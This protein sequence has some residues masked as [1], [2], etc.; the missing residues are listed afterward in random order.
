[1]NPTKPLIMAFLVIICLAAM[2]VAAQIPF[3][4]SGYVHFP[5]GSA[6]LDPTVTITNLNTGDILPVMTLPTSNYYQAKPAPLLNE[7]SEN[8]VLEFR[9]SAGTDPVVIEH[10]IMA[11]DINSGAL[12]LNITL[13]TVKAATGS[14]AG[15]P[16]LPQ[17]PTA[18]TQDT[19]AT[20]T[21]TPDDTTATMT[22]VS[23]STEASSS[24]DSKEKSI[25]GFE[26]VFSSVAMV[27]CLMWVRKRGRI[28]IHF[29][30]K[31]NRPHC[32]NRKMLLHLI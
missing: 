12:F 7:I 22:P 31:G 14:G 15:D 26:I 21:T 17:A 19:T 32:V 20:T 5:D 27:A 1:M 30:S 11:S 29:K 18:S 16:P 4:I 25:P 2:P 6:C 3:E 10:R 9:A 8:D 13:G 24:A 23:T 28:G